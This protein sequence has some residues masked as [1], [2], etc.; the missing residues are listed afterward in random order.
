MKR[1]INF[2]LIMTSWFSISMETSSEAFGKLWFGDL[3]GHDQKFQTYFNSLQI[4]WLFEIGP[5]I[6]WIN[7]LDFFHIL[8]FNRVHK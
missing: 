6:S 2:L 8:M 3:S 5:Y 7:L 4:P 1:V